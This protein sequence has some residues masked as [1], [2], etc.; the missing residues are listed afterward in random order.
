MELSKVLVTGGAG[1]MGSH[2]VDALIER[3]YEVVVID[4]LSA[5]SLSFLKEHFGNKR[6]HFHRADLLNDPL[7]NF[8]EGCDAVWH[9]AAN[10]EVR[11][12]AE[13]PKIHIEQNVLATHKVLEEMRKAG[14]KT[15]VFTSTSTI[16]GEAEQIPTPENLS[17]IH[18]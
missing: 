16:Y 14:I 4:N 1:F 2:V 5:G 17:L 9:L 18:I 11:I 13:N 15:L 12:G 6:F 8:F 3:G 7:R 10:P